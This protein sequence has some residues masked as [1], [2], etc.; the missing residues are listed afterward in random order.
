MHLVT[1]RTHSGTSAGRLEGDQIVLLEAPDV[2]SLLRSSGLGPAGVADG[3]TIPLEG[4]DLAPV[5]PN[6]DKII[7]V[8]INYADHIAEMGHDMPDSPTYFA[9]FQRALTGPRDDIWL[10]H[11][12]IS[13]QCDWEAELVIVVGR[14][15][16]SA[17]ASEAAEAIAGFSV[18]NDFSVRDWQRRSS[19]F[20]AGKTFEHASPLGPAMVTTD[21][22]GDGSG[23]EISTI[24]N[25]VVKQH[26]NTSHLVFGPVDILVDLSRIMT[27]DPG[28][29]VFT[30]TPGGV[31]VARTP[32]EW[33]EPGDVVETSIGGI[34]SLRNH[35]V[36]APS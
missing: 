23:L 30:G 33:L 8:G 19:Q 36:L 34:G 2:G 22:L 16:R 3:R 35:C 26:S 13:V 15:L 25:G 14:E 1:V 7:C 31:G 10:P 21:E 9:K 28:D 18:G 20:L 24:V 29:I 4:A 27:L 6:P 11:P 32:P 12:D 17:T 5:V